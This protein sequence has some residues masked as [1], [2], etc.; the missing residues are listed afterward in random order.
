[1]PAKPPDIIVERWLPYKQQKRQV[2]YEKALSPNDNLTSTTDLKQKNNLII[3]YANPSVR[4]EKQM[5]SLGI[6]RRD[7]FNQNKDSN[8][9]SPKNIGMNI[10]LIYI[11]FPFFIFLEPIY[12]NYTPSN[13]EQPNQSSK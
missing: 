1:M 7:P 13:I 6:V 3:Q 11:S 9:P 8:L 4:I 10:R 12:H 5:R 2:I